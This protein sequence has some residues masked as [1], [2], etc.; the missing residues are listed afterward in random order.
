MK[1]KQIVE[2]APKFLSEF[3]GISE[4]TAVERIKIGSKLV[5]D[6]W[7]EFSGGDYENLDLYTAFYRKVKNY[8]FDLA[9]FNS[10]FR[11]EWTVG[12][13]DAILDNRIPLQLQCEWPKKP[14]LLEVGG[15]GGELSL[16]LS[17]M[18]EVTHYDVPSVTFDYA[19]F[20]GER[21]GAD[22]KYT[23]ELPDEKFDVVSMMDVFE[24][25]ADPM[26]LVND[27]CDC[28][29]EDALFVSTAF[30]T[31]DSHYLHLTPNLQRDYMTVA[32]AN[33]FCLWHTHVIQTVGI[34]DEEAQGT[35]GLF[36]FS[37]RL[38]RM[39][40]ECQLLLAHKASITPVEEDI[41]DINIPHTNSVEKINFTMTIG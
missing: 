15:G 14:T 4:D 36:R 41:E 13:F 31:S 7:E 3:Y 33:N 22:I 27:V 25:S 40:A 29:K 19:K 21:Y 1:I 12:I 10:E 17:D 6:E 35:V 38:N 39:M 16:A 24:H 18:F 2:E 5:K 30:Y 28:M 23:T 34:Q 32:F 9:K 37:E 26:N 8:P 11:L 20:R